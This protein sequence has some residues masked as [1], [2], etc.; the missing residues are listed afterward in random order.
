MN[1]KFC[2]ICQDYIQLFHNYKQLSCCDIYFHKKCYNDM[3][4]N[5]INTCPHCRT[6]INNTT[7]YDIIYIYF[8]NII[9]Y[10]IIIFNNLCLY[11]LYTIIILLII[12]YYTYIYLFS[13]I[14]L[15][16]YNNNIGDSLLIPIFFNIILN[17]YLCVIYSID[18]CDVMFS[19]CILFYY[20]YNMNIDDNDD[21]ELNTNNEVY[22][23]KLIRVLFIDLII[24]T[25]IHIIIIF[26]YI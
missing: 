1:T 20:Y 19:I 14:F 12:L 25:L 3:L 18:C 11:F 7:N 22:K 5:N 21:D 26:Q 10:L 23:S 2:V 13:L 15:N 9:N 8:Y 16:I 6:I 17:Y 4:I 24:I